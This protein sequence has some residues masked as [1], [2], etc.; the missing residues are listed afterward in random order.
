MFGYEWNEILT[1]DALWVAIGFAG[2]GLFF[3]RWLVQW[4]SSERQRRSVIPVS[5]WY[6]SMA[7][8]VVL[9]AYSIYREDPVFIMGNVF[10]SAVY[11]RNLYLIRRSRSEDAS[12][13]D[14]ESAKP[15]TE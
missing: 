3:V 11:A 5:F 7:G 1:V 2:Q 4:F 10:N 12:R 9:L 13:E 8:A 14:V 15:L 6:L